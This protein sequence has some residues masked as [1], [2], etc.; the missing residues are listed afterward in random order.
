MHSLTQSARHQG[1][2][3]LLGAEHEHLAHDSNLARGELVA[4]ME[5]DFKERASTKGATR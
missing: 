5:I 4:S 1:D 3:Q 2:R